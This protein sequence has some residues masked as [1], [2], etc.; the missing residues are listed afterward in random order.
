MRLSWRDSIATLLVAIG[1]V[2]YAA[3]AVGSAIPGFRE[4]AA[5]AIA[6]L[7]LGVAASISAVVPGFSELMHGSRPYLLGAS[8]LGAVAL[9]AGICTISGADAAVGLGLLMLATAALWAMSTVRHLGSQHPRQH[10]QDPR[11]V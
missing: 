10:P 8:A 9:G 7:A 5:V 4:P 1:A 6:I 2:V 11:A 3:W